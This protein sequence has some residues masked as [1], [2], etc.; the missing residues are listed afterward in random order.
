MYGLRVVS[1]ADSDSRERDVELLYRN[2][3]GLLIGLMPIISIKQ[4]GRLQSH[5]KVAS[6]QS[7]QV[8][9]TRGHALC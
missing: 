3:I 2:D 9:R 4:Y 6:T 5:T 7:K 1:K 8:A